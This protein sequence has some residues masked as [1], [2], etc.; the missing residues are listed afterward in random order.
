MMKLWL[1]CVEEISN[2]NQTMK[3]GLLNAGILSVLTTVLKTRMTFPPSSQHTVVLKNI[4]SALISVCMENELSCRMICNGDILF[5]CD[6]LFV[7]CIWDSSFVITLMKFL[8]V[9]SVDIVSK[10]KVI[11][12][13]HRLVG[14]VILVLQHYLEINADIVNSCFDMI[15]CLAGIED[16]RR[17]FCQSKICIWNQICVGAVIHMSVS[18]SIVRNCLSALSQLWDLNN[19]SVLN[20]KLLTDN[21]STTL[22]VERALS[23]GLVDVMVAALTSVVP[24]YPTLHRVCCIISHC[25][26]YCPS[27]QEMFGEFGVCNSLISILCDDVEAVELLTES[28]LMSAISNEVNGNDNFVV[29]NL[30]LVHIC[31]ALTNLLDHCPQNQEYAVNSGLCAILVTL[32]QSKAFASINSRT[33]ISTLICSCCRDNLKIV[34]EFGKRNIS[35]VLT[36]MLM[37]LTRTKSMSRIPIH[38]NCAQLVSNIVLVMKFLSLDTHTASELR[39]LLS[40]KQ[41]IP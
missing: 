27:S 40:N 25:C 35:E 29:E 41:T 1:T 9:V 3:Q 24:D 22:Q 20:N 21:K 32:L 34:R 5:N 30:S 13:K 37:S 31:Q 38:E 33:S 16:G 15:E 39:T 14:H 11:S 17:Q 19:L 7:S 2:R 12:V 8:R 18:P 36:Q 10:A 4:F 23:C 6:S 28:T 26:R